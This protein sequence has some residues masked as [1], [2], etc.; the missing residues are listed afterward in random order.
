[1]SDTKE[2]SIETLLP[3]GAPKRVRLQDGSE[4]ILRTAFT[5]PASFWDA[6]KQNK[7]TLQ[8][9]GISPKRQPNGSWIVNHWAAV[10]PV[11]AKAE[12]ARRS[13]VAEASR[14][15]DANVDLPRPAG[16]DYLPYQKAGV[17]FGLECWA[18]KRGVLIGDEMGL[19]KTIQAIGLMNCTADI[20][21]VIIVC[22]NTLKLNWARELK[23]WLTRPMSVEVQYSNKPFSRADIVIVNFDIV[24]KFLPALND[25]TWDLR[26]VDESQYIKNP[27]A[28]RTKST[29]AIRAA[30]KVALTGTPIENRPIELWPVLNDLDP[31]AWPKGNFFQYARRYCAAKQNGFGWDFSGHS[32]EAELQHKLRSSIMVRRLKKD[33]LKE[34][35]P[36]QRQ[37]IELDSDGCREL[38]ALEASMLE[39]RE[40][41]LASLRAR[42]E[43]ARA[44]ESREDYAEAVHAL[45][46]GQGAAFEDMAELRHKVAAAKLPQCLAFIRDAME[47]GKI[48][49][50][51]HHLGI[52]KD[53][54]DNLTESYTSLSDGKSNRKVEDTGS[55]SNAKRLSGHLEVP[56]S[57]RTDKAGG[58]EKFAG[59][60][61]SRV[62]SM[63]GQHSDTWKVSDSGIPHGST[64]AA[65]GQE[66]KGAL[67]NNLGGCSNSGPVS[68]VGNTAAA[69]HSLQVSSEQSIPGQ[70]SSG[71]GICAGQRVGDKLEGQR[72][73]E[74][75]DTR[76]NRAPRSVFESENFS[77]AVVTGDISIQDRQIAVDTFQNDPRC[78]VFVG[79]L[80]AAEGLT[81]TAG[82]HVIFV[83]LQWV[84]GKHAQME[85][86]AHRIGQ[87][88]SV[89][90]SYLVL[91][92]SLDAHMS[93]TIVDKLNVIDS[94]LDRITDWTEADVED[95]EPVTKVRLTFERVAAEARLVSDRCVELVHQGMK[96]LAGVC[97]GACKLDDVGFSAVDVRIGHALAH[98][99]SITQKQAALGWRI[100]C[101]YSRQLGPAFIAEL[102]AAAATK[103]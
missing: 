83:E 68:A 82:T 8:A 84:P 13:V 14:A 65:A 88:D 38:L 66:D 54:V 57:M 70:N 43:L 99:T 11:A 97:D 51:C 16:L 46:Q 27:K 6:W 93:R 80:A 81:L 96:M 94:C 1:M 55:G 89:L 33:V 56:V 75:R 95:V 85:D 59:G 52:V 12:Q 100:L 3:W 41:A 24:H 64:S 49:V 7:A 44:G 36:K 74:Q 63:S 26:I 60:G 72:P 76:R 31:S 34:L 50:F 30:R 103:E 79:N 61:L 37:V 48:L 58:R 45:R 29:L 5:V 28:R 22:P 40:A 53:I 78:Q 10:D 23:K 101:K 67:R 77:V 47:S 92:G 42:V 90:C 62:S 35:P 2:I 20:K 69:G 71:Q 39:E 21:S 18:A 91:E 17:A 15:T 87:K 73:E 102:K 86:R 4:R 25:R 19:G 32:N 98:R 9:A